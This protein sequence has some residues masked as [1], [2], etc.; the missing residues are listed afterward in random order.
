MWGFG[1]KSDEEMIQCC[2]PLKVEVFSLVEED[3]LQK[4]GWQPAEPAVYRG[5]HGMT[6]VEGEKTTS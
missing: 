6:V 3:F 4:N 2:R 5:M 1:D